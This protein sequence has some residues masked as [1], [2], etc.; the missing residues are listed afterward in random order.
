MF[1]CVNIQ[2]PRRWQVLNFLWKTFLLELHQI[3]WT[4]DR[5]QWIYMVASA[6]NW[7]DVDLDRRTDDGRW[8]LTL[9]PGWTLQPSSPGSC[10]LQP[11]YIVLCLSYAK[12]FEHWH[13]HLDEHYNHP[14]LQRLN[15]VSVS[16]LCNIGWPFPHSQFGHFQCPKQKSKTTTQHK[17]SPN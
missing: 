5:E 14:G 10:Q 17:P 3:H 4:L 12:V 13:L 7:I 6:G 2:A 15:P 9:L 11:P 16:Y 1:V 8:T